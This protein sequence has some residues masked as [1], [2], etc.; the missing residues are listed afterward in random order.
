M[1]NTATVAELVVDHEHGDPRY[2]ETARRALADLMK[3]WGLD[4]PPVIDHSMPHLS[5]LTDE[6]LHEEVLTLARDSFERLPRGRR[7]RLEIT[8]V[9]K[10]APRPAAPESTAPDGHVSCPDPAGVPGAG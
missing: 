9:P 7:S 6:E 1:Q 4:T 10:H 5:H 8:V 3:L 2:L